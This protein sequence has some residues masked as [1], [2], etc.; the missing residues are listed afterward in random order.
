MQPH[1]GAHAVNAFSQTPANN[2]LMVQEDL[3]SFPGLGTVLGS[4]CIKGSINIIMMGLGG[5]FIKQAFK[6]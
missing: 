2:L 3:R 1:P 4:G 5:G 6:V